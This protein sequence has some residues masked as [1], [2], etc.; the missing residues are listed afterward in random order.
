MEL[1]RRA[2]PASSEPPHLGRRRAPRP[3]RTQ[4]LGARVTCGVRRDTRSNMELMEIKHVFGAEEKKRGWQ[5]ASAASSFD[6]SCRVPPCF[7]LSH[8]AGKLPLTRRRRR[9]RRASRTTGPAGGA[10]RART[11]G[12][13]SA[14]C[15]IDI[16]RSVRSYR[17]RPCTGRR[18]TADVRVQVAAES[19]SSSVPGN[20]SRDPPSDRAAGRQTTE[21]IAS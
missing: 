2:E 9:R 17:T 13:L 11:T 15:V 3:Y 21:L 7:L 19:S 1:D 8:L 16:D 4:L 20:P 12:A 5:V 6:R 14:G 18:T 10:A